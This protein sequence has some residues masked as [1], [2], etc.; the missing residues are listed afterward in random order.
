MGESLSPSKAPN[1]GRDEEQWRWVARPSRSDPKTP[2]VARPSRSDPLSGPERDALATAPGSGP[3]KTAKPFLVRTWPH[4]AGYGGQKGA[5]YQFQL[6]QSC[7]E[8]N[9]VNLV[10]ACLPQ[11]VA[12][13]DSASLIPIMEN[14]I[15]MPNEAARKE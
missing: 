12:E 7:G 9:E 13:S 14:Q 6:A 10:A 1:A 4:E 15:S 3:W 11:S 8:K 2:K 5:G